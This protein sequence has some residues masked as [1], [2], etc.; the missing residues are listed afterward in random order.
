MTEKH[1]R[2]LIACSGTGGHF[3]PGYSLARVMSAKGWDPLF[4]VKTGD[5]ARDVLDKAGLPWT[6]LALTG[7]PRG[8]HP[9]AL[10][11]FAGQLRASVKRMDIILQ[12][13][14]PDVV[15]GFGGYISFPAI[16]CARKHGIRSIIHEANSVMGMANRWSAKYASLVAWGLIDPKKPLP[17][18]TAAPGTPVRGEFAVRLSRLEA[19]QKLGL[20]PNRLTVT[21]FGGSQ[22]ARRINDAI[23]NSALRITAARSDVQFLHITG[24]RDY[25][26]IKT[27]YGPSPKNIFVLEYCDRMNLALRAADLAITRA[28]AST[29][30]ELIAVQKPAILIPFPAATNAHQDAN[31]RIF[32]KTGCAVVVK[33]D[34]S[35][36]KQLYIEMVRLLDVP[37][38]LDVMRHSYAEAGFPNP[39]E[40]ANKLAY[41]IEELAADV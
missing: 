34:A 21:V 26:E 18:D 25:V 37:G 3:Y 4:L 30:S 24:R 12:D 7:L 39:L 27:L 40:A 35:F 10:A 17:K 8:L 5:P 28:G 1:K 15:I 23:V 20:N 32:E 6:E 2:L 22:G 29:L 31:A 13:F 41:A 36:A 33:E 11:G 19:R 9:F 16:Y 38:T 14:R